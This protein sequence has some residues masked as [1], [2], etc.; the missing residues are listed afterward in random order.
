[1]AKLNKCGNGLSNV[2]GIECDMVGDMFVGGSYLHNIH[3]SNM[4]PSSPSILPNTHDEH[5][6]RLNGHRVP[7]EHVREA[8]QTPPIAGRALREHDQRPT[9]SLADLLQRGWRRAGSGGVG[10]NV[11]RRTNDS[12]ERDFLESNHGSSGTCCTTG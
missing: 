12:K 2:D 6:E 7:L 3:V 5:L 10:R 4:C 1:M 11:A 8:E 9:S